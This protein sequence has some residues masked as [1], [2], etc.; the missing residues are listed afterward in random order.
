MDDI[1]EN[2]ISI[3][4]NLWQVADESTRL[5]ELISQRFNLP[6]VMAKIIALRGIGVDDVEHF[7]TPKISTLMPDPYVLNLGNETDFFPEKQ[8]TKGIEIPQKQKCRN[9]AYQL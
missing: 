5:A 1:L 7:L 6:Y 3:G 9:I 4:G 8:V 2:N